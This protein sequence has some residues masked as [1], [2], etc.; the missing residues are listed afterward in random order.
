MCDSLSMLLLLSSELLLHELPLTRSHYLLLS[1]TFGEV[2]MPR[3]LW[4]TLV[5]LGYATHPW[6]LNSL[7]RWS[8]NTCH[9]LSRG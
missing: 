8:G 5:N 7:D 6:L 3:S 1:G 2:E 4:C 9:I